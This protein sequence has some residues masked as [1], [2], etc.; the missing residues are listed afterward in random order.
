MTGPPVHRLRPR[1]RAIFLSHMFSAT[2][3]PRAFLP[4]HSPVSDNDPG[5][6]KDLFLTI[7]NILLLNNYKSSC[8][9][10]IPDN[11]RACAVVDGMGGVCYFPQLC[12]SEHPSKD[13][14]S[15]ALTWLE[16]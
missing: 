8:A 16:S 11:T 6:Q 9:R 2:L 14:L 4:T 1:P 3:E 7:S 12:A 13:R 5:V 15:W 10:C